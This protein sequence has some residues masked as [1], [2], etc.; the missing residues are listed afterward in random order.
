LPWRFEPLEYHHLAGLSP[1]GR[2]TSMH[3]KRG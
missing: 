1:A 2:G 3:K